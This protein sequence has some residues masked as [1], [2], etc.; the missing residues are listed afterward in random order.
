MEI[1]PMLNAKRK[2][3]KLIETVFDVLYLGTVLV[4][5]FLLCMGSDTGSERWLF[6]LMAMILG[7]GDSFH[8]IPRVYAMWDGKSGDHTAA[9]GVGK[10]VASITMT[11]FYVVLWGVGTARYAN[12]F[13]ALMTQAVFALAAARI[14]LCLFPQNGW[15][16]QRPPLKWAILRNI[17]F[18]VLGMLV[19]ALFAEGSARDGGFP[20]LWLAILISF[21]CYLPVVLFSERSPKV[22]M[23]MLPKSCAYAAIVLMGFSLPAA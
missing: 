2:Q 3:M 8:L 23:L 20:F 21:A 11:V 16:S 22:G 4:S 14:A 17:P 7:A 5:A 19:M 18:F 10:L 13:P 15:T 6:G 1:A 12:A 9:L